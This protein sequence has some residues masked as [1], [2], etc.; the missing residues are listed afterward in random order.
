VLP[1]VND[2]GIAQGAVTYHYHLNKTQKTAFTIKGEKN[3]K[4]AYSIARQYSKVEILEA[5]NDSYPKIS[6]EVTNSPEKK[7]AKLLAKGNI[8]ALFY[9]ESEFGPRA[10]GH[11]SILSNP[12]KSIYR[13]RINREVKF[14]EPFRPIAP[15]V[16]DRYYEKFFKGSPDRPFMLKVAKVKEEAID[17]ISSVVH[18]DGTAR[19]QTVYKDLNPF[20]YSILEEFNSLC[21]IPVL[22]NTSF[23]QRNTPIVETPHDALDAF[24]KMDI[25]YLFIDDYLIAKT[26]KE[27]RKSNF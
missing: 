22:S 6:Y 12:T 18:I 24:L 9:K 14:R 23:N 1:H 13:E 4:K 5:I 15:I 11:R 19:V 7:I 3:T 25:D 16:L 2:A 20:I 26:N 10:L 17:T 21:G 27:E 8:V